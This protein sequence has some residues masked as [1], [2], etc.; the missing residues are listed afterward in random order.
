MEQEVKRKPEVRKLV[1]CSSFSLGASRFKLQVYRFAN[2]AS[3]EKR[4]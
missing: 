3:R 2:C 4:K 1:L